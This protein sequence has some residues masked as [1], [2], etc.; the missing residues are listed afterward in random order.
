VA[1]SK[2]VDSSSALI[3]SASKACSVRP[4]GCCTCPRSL[5]EYRRSTLEYSWS[6]P[7]VL[8]LIHSQCVECALRAG[9]W[10]LPIWS[11]RRCGQRRAQSRRRCGSGEPSPGADVAAG[12]PS[13]GADVAAA[14][15]SL[16]AG[17]RDCVEKESENPAETEKLDRVALHGSRAA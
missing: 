15:Y 14:A 4:S 17:E 8:S 6:T 13:P 5:Q 3:S 12:E 11:R 7:G 2:P 1:G 9:P 16:R 10:Q